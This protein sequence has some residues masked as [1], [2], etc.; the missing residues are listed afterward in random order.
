MLKV[1][2]KHH[3]KIRGTL[4]NKSHVYKIVYFIH[5]GLNVN[6]DRPNH[7]TAKIS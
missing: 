7:I 3:I 2:G 4:L 1:Q 5:D 6:K